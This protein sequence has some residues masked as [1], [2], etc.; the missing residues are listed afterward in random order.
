M[1]LKERLAELRRIWNG[2]PRRE[3]RMTAIGWRPPGENW[4]EDPNPP[5]GAPEF[6]RVVREGE[7]PNAQ[8]PAPARARLTAAERRQIE[9]D[10]RREG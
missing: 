8:Q 6:Y 1:T 7:K 10:L 5:S 9:F 4:T 3:I 2:R